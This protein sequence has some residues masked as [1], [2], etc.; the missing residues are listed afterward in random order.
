MAG[1]TVIAPLSAQ[2]QEPNVLP[3]QGGMITLV[4]CFLP[5]GAHH[6][7]Y[8]LAKPVIGSVESVTDGTCAS[9]IDEQAVELKD[10]GGRHLGPSML[11]HVIEVSGRL[12]KVEGAVNLKDLRELHVRSFKPVPVV[13][14]A[15]AA[16]APV[17]EPPSYTPPAPQAAIPPL[18]ET[19]VATSGTLPTPLPKTASPLPLIGLLSLLSFFGA[20]AFHLV[21]V[22]RRD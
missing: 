6:S 2:A 16:P 8:V 10:T 21:G 19:P 17:S 9:P 18:E 5:G 20:A 14:P 22:R 15:A 1:A 13:I 7:K 12:E 11:N 3:E 4:G